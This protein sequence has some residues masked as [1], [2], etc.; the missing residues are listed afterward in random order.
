MPPIWNIHYARWVID[1]GEPEIDVKADFDWFSL[2]FSGTL[3]KTSRKE[4]SSI[5]VA[6]YRYQ[7]TAE[8][9]YI[10]EK[11]C[12]IDFGLT[13]IADPNS[14]PPEC[15]KG[16]YVTG[17]LALSLP[18]CTE[19]APEEILKTLSRKWYVNEIHADTTPYISH[20]DNP[21]F[22]FRD[23]SRIKFEPVVSTATVKAH[24]YIL[25]CTKLA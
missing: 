24:D 5:P 19:I 8:V 4:K 7:L 17:E 20:P 18:L 13:A 10:S 12:V 22:F 9:V 25:H 3:M 21:K 15:K 14:V 11:S 6:D 1:D 23:E 16:E 2:A